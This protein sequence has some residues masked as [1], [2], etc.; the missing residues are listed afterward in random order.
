VV[1]IVVVGLFVVGF[2]LTQPDQTSTSGD[3][4]PSR[5]TTSTSVDDDDDGSDGADGDAPVEVDSFEELDDV[6]SGSGA[7]AEPDPA[8]VEEL[9]ELDG[10]GATV[11][12]WDAG[13]Q[14][15]DLPDVPGAYGPMIGDAPSYVVSCCEDRVTSY[16]LIGR[17]GTTLEELQARVSAELPNDTTAGPVED[18]P[19]CP[20]QRFTSDTIE[21]AFGADQQV[22]AVYYLPPDPSAPDGLPYATLSLVTDGDELVC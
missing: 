15:L 16:L 19:G 18:R 22:A 6:L 5:S 3:R 17:A 20:A 1:V 13:H 2:V 21:A 12:Q 11:S 14:K 7:L 10:F 9:A 4:E 8:F